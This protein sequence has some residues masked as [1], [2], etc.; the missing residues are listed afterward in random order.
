MFR[1]IVKIT[2][3][4]FPTIAF[5]ERNQVLNF[6]FVNYYEGSDGW[7]DLTNKGKLRIPKNLY[8]RD[9]AGKLKPL[10]GTNVN[11]GGFSPGVPL[12]LRGD[13]VKMEA[14]YKY[15]NSAK[16]EVTDIST[17]FQGYVS[18]VNSKIPIEVDLEDNMWKLKQLPVATKTFTKNDSLE[19]ILK[20]IT[21][22]SGFTV[23]ALTQTTFGTFSIGNETAAQVLQRLRKEYHFESYFRGNELRSGS[24]VYVPSEAVTQNFIFQ[25]NI[26]SDD[27]EYK[28][29]DDIVLSAVARNTITVLTGKHTKDGH[30]KTKRTRLEVLVTLRNGIKTIKEIKKGE[31]LPANTEGERRT[32]F[33]PGATTVEQLGVLAYDE[34]TKY[35]YTGLRGK[36][37]TFGIPFVKFGD[38]ALIQDKKLPERDGLYKIKSVKYYGGYDDGIRQEIELDYRVIG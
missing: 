3:Q 18:N 4:Q 14:G 7:R 8:Y 35:Y 19:D 37:T 10:Y 25:E 34:L 11:V 33:F 1:T 26:I 6:D 12:I 32:L 31:T 22:G 2:V 38:N 29:K 28:R 5:P 30:A 36:F 27:L 17:V 23:N 24:I 16:R 20:F 21:A 15:F 9:A 13:A